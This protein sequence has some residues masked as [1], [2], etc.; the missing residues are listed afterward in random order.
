MS[1][2]LG[3]SNSP[4]LKTKGVEVQDSE[5]GIVRVTRAN[6]R[7]DKEVNP[8]PPWSVPFHVIT[9]RTPTDSLIQPKT[10]IQSNQMYVLNV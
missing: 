4:F 3:S 6:A 1:R 8:L 10:P 5:C 2:L 9:S 7:Q